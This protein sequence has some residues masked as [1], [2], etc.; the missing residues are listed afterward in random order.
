VSVL[1]HDIKTTA[2]YTGNVTIQ[3]KYDSQGLSLEDEQNMKIW[4]WNETSGN[5]VDITTYVDTTNDVVYGVAPHLSIF[6]ITNDLTL[7]GNMSLEGEII[8]RLP[9]MP[10]EPPSGL[11]ALKY[12][13]IVTTKSYTPPITIRLAYDDAAMSLVEEIFMRMWVWNE[14]STSWVDIT[15]RVDTKNNVIYGLASHLSI[16][17]I[18]SLKPPPSEIAILDSTC[19][20]T[21]AGQGFNV[22]I[23]FTVENQAG[24]T[25]TFDILVYCNLTILKTYSVTLNPIDNLTFFFKWDT[26]SWAKGNYAISVFNR[27]ISWVVVTIPGDL[28]GNFA[29]QLVDLVILARAYGSQPGEQNWNS[30]ADIDG[31]NIVGLS[32]LVMMARNYGKAQP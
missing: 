17:G 15:A 4:L 13:E 27:L 9:A 24:F 22:T 7:E 29:V 10:P 32:D 26:T 12:Y 25:K 21:V 14:T 28:D 23:D 2:N 3:F 19:S 11:V 1:C 6:G 30:N 8:T 31:N 18:T 5:W 20:K 16:F